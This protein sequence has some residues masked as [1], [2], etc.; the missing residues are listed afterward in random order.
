M[1]K[2]FT[3]VKK[4]NTAQARLPSRLPSVGQAVGQAL[5]A[6]I[7]I[8]V[9]LSLFGVVAVSLLST[10]TGQSAVG[11]SESARALYL[12]HAGLEWHMQ[13]LADDTDWTDQATPV[14]QNLG[15]G[16][17][18][19]ALSNI[20]A[21]SMDIISTG[22]VVGA[23][24]R[25]RERWVSATLKKAFPGSRF[26]VFWQLDGPGAR[27]NFT[28]TGGG[29]HIAGDFWSVG[30]CN[31]GSNSDVTNGWIYY[32][33]GE[34]VSGAGSYTA[35]VVE[36]PF[37]AMPT[38]DASSYDTLMA[39]YD[40]DIANNSSTDTAYQSGTITLT[41]NTLEFQDF[42]TRNDLTITGYGK[43]VANRD[44]LLHSSSGSG[45]QTLTITPS[46]GA[47]EILA[48]RNFTISTSGGN[49]TVIINSG[50]RLYAQNPAAANSFQINESTVTTIEGALLLA[51]RRL[52]I[53]GDA[54]VTNSTAYVDYNTSSTTNNYLQIT[55]SGTTVSG[56]VISRG[57]I[58]PSL[59][60]NSAAQVT[61][62]VYQYGS[63]TEGMAQVNGASTVT[64]AFLCRQFYNNSLGPATFTGNISSLPSPLPNGFEAFEV[65]VEPNSWDGL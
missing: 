21:A 63:T 52:V 39:G 25:N 62:L 23:D 40:T 49:R 16:S 24:G 9:V 58:D 10:Q 48:G 7:L 31:L 38:F 26:A 43:I 18:T 54:T 34:S 14:T 45:S 20:T 1:I 64:G 17:F 57:R 22:R 37:P 32:G 41:G 33:A 12:A 61:G 28:N 11:L 27:L 60:I 44:V 3:K 46:G 15:A 53:Q 8:M 13:Q 35:Q 2:K 47:I 42:R 59:R 30:S 50:T 51:R 4:S 55:G 5:I 65:Y 56:A 6:A 36:L 29:T 19:V